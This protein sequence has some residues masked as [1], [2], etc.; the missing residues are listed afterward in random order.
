MVILA[1]NKAVERVHPHE[2]RP[3]LSEGQAEKAPG[4]SGGEL[5]DFLEGYATFLQ[6]LDAM[7]LQ[8]KNIFCH[9]AIKYSKTA[10]CMRKNSRALS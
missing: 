9:S 1:P 7:I 8:I 10:L 6:Q 3:R 2:M 5:G 4:V